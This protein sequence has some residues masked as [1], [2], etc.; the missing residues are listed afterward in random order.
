[1]RTGPE[2]SDLASVVVL[3]YGPAAVT[4]AAVARARRIVGHDGDVAVVAAVPPGRGPARDAARRGARLATETGTRGLI[5]ALTASAEGAVLVLHDDV[6]LTAAG[7]RRLVD[8]HRATGSVAV[9]MSNDTATDHFVGA[10][11]AVKHAAARCSQLG[12]PDALALPRPAR[13]VRPVCIVTERSLAADLAQRGLVDARVR[14]DDVDLGFVAVP[15]AVTAHDNRC[16]RRLAGPDGPDGRALL[17]AHMIVKDEEE[18]LPALLDSIAGLVDRVEV[19]DTG[20]TDR[21]VEIAEAAGC[22]VIHRN[23]RDDFGWARNE[24]LEQCRDAWYVLMVD[25]DDVVHCAD[26]Q[27]LRRV[28]ATY[29]DEYRAYRVA[30]TSRAAADEGSAPSA[31]FH[32]PRIFCPDGVRWRGALHEA[33]FVLDEERPIEGPVC[34]LL[35]IEHRGYSSELIEGRGKVD[36]NIGIAS[37]AYEADPTPKHA[38]ELARS[39]MMSPDHDP[40]VLQSL[41]EEAL[42]A[43]RE[44]R[45]AIASYVLAVTARACLGTAQAERACDLASEALELVPG[46][47]MALAAFVDACRALGDDAR[48]VARVDE[49]RGRPSVR[50]MYDYPV[51]RAQARLRTAGARARLGW[52]GDAVDEALEVAAE[53]ELVLDG[54][55]DVLAPVRDHAPDQLPEVVLALVQRDRSGGVMAAVSTTLPP[56]VTAELGLAYV[57]TGG[58]HPDVCAVALMA[59]VVSERWELLAPWQEHLETIPSDVRGRVAERARALGHADVADLLAAGVPAGAPR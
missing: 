29:V 58:T 39:L 11:P 51:L 2:V 1:V 52:L 30:V 37:A 21:T 19:C 50:A 44:G 54:W 20:S 40:V 34:E 12:D 32:S 43:A 41:L 26:P 47:D 56:A 36:R 57:L 28:L 17:V 46:D 27:E 42:P 55:E 10:L 25:A 49:L 31:A 22:N 8:A 5:E 9:A 6:L 7:A 24:V 35:A 23:W 53:T 15:G 59:T 18:M 33:P 38:L 48:L 45:P 16:T 13:V 14:F 3:A 4:D